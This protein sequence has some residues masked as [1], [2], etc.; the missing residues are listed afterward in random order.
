MNKV[1]QQKLSLL[2]QEFLLHDNQQADRLQRWRNLEPESALFL[3]ILVRSKQ[4]EQVLEIGTSNGFS[5]LWLADAMQATQG[6][7]T[8]LEIEAARTLLAQQ[9]LTQFELAER[10]TCLTID[11]AVFLASAQPIYDLIFLDAEREA[12]LAYWPDLKRLLNGYASSLLVVDNVISH[13][14]Q[15]EELITLIAAD[16]GFVHS[17]VA[18]GAGLL[19]VTKN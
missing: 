8:S 4:A 19:L 13:R 10:V 12:Y 17:I 18:V 2:H 9:H 6:F 15:V 1:L 11:A 5:T 14:D 3:S 16:E 7:L